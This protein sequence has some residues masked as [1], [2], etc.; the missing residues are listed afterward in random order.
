[1]PAAFWCS[2]VSGIATITICILQKRDDFSAEHGN[3]KGST[4]EGAALLGESGGGSRAMDGTQ[5]GAR[6]GGQRGEQR[7]AEAATSSRGGASTE[8]IASKKAPEEEDA[9][10]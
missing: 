6:Q 3:P 9:L 5:G 7:G 10:C 8:I 2:T 1:L 4:G